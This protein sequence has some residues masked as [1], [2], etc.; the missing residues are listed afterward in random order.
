MTPLLTSPSIALRTRA[1]CAGCN[2]ML[3][4]FVTGVACHSWIAPPVRAFQID[5][6][7]CAPRFHGHV[8]ENTP[9]CATHATNPFSQQGTALSKRQLIVQLD[10]PMEAMAHDCGHGRP[11]KPLLDACMHAKVAAKLAPATS[12]PCEGA[13]TQVNPPA[14]HRDQRG[15]AYMHMPTAKSSHWQL[16]SKA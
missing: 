4:G 16:S 12:T 6:G 7:K 5:S 3:E 9:L 1:G 14:V 11:R 13:C 8:R 10:G 15:H 2:A